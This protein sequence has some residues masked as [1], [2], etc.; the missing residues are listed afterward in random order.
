[1]TMRDCQAWGSLLGA[2]ASSVP[3]EIRICRLF[4]GFVGTGDSVSNKNTAKDF[5]GRLA[6]KQTH[7][8]ILLVNFLKHPP[9]DSQSSGSQGSR[10]CQ[11]SPFLALSELPASELTPLLTMPPR[12]RRVSHG[13]TSCFSLLNS[14]EDT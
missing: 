8:V 14:W 10:C 5:K 1:M 11:Q 6:P 3:R 4:K 12:T 13:H 7:L 2:V 9:V